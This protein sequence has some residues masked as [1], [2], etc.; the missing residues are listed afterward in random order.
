MR[1]RAL[2]A[3]PEHF[4]PRAVQILGKLAEVELRRVD[5]SGLSRAFQTHDVV[6]VRLAHRITAD[7]MGESPRCRI[8]ACATTGLD[9]IDLESCGTK[10]V[11]VISLRGET[12][13]LRQIRATSELTLGLMLA[14]LRRIPD[15][16]ASV[17]DGHWD[18]DRFRGR[19]LAGRTAG[20]VGVGRVGSL[21]AGYLQALGMEVLGYDPSPESWPDGVERVHS[22]P[23]LLERSHVVSLHPVY[24]PGTRQLIG[25]PELARMRADAVLVNTSR[26]AVVDETAL[27][28]ALRQGRLA[29]AALDVLVGE[30]DIG[31]RH[32][33]VAYAREHQ[34]LLIVP[35]IGGN[36]HE[37]F[38]KT[39]VFIAER[40]ARALESENAT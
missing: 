36:T 30:P 22:L 39:E 32:P 26:G 20:I 28:D 11:R 35:H 15:A 1:R 18:R 25:E 8:I 40:V 23:E 29:G 7:L 17:K 27:V 10:G 33:L 12:E 5:R 38:E 24:G 37:S 13:F 19:E 6:W 21:V 31:A 14:L 4:S 3:E 9:H 16:F 2:I 34:N